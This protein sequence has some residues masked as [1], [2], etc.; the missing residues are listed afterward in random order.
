MKGDQE[1]IVLKE[2]SEK[3]KNSWEMKYTSRNENVCTMKL[4]KSL[5]N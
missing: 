3:K 1:A 5:R 4:R 2:H